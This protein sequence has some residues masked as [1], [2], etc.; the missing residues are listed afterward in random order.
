MRAWRNK[1]K[2]RFTR[3]IRENRFF[4]VFWYNL[5]SHYY[6]YCCCRG[7][8]ETIWE[9]E[10]GVCGEM[11]PAGP[12]LSRCLGYRSTCVCVCRIA[13][14]SR[15]NRERI[16]N[17]NRN[18]LNGRISI[19]AD[20]GPLDKIR[21]VTFNL[22]FSFSI[23]PAFLRFSFHLYF[24]CLFITLTPLL[25]PLYLSFPMVS[26]SILLYLPSFLHPSLYVILRSLFVSLTLSVSRCFSFILA[27]RF[28]FFFLPSSMSYSPHIFL[29]F[30]IYFN[31]PSISLSPIRISVV[32]F[33]FSTYKLIDHHRISCNG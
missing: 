12:L 17:S 22:R 13:C 32:L 3:L 10:I 1:A 30:L 7:R 6:C 26:L 18:P 29:H 31:R 16:K 25:F 11:C 2:R 9:W 27:I 4:T 23:Y 5:G 19:F 28:P 14:W 33:P 21:K 20:K 24:S 15:G 8:D